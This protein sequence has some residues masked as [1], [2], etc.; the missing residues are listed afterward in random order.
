MMDGRHKTGLRRAII[1]S[2][3]QVPDDMMAVAQ[4]SSNGVRVGLGQVP[5]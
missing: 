1:M 4:H 5:T 3:P 2:F